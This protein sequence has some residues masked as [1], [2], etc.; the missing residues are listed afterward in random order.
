VAKRA[1]KPKPAAKQPK[2]KLQTKKMRVTAAYESGRRY[3]IDGLGKGHNP[4]TPGL[5]EADA[6]ALGWAHEDKAQRA[7][8]NLKVHEAP[9]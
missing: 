2:P 6:F 4:Y 3:R 1:D 7:V 5:T 9:R 8:G